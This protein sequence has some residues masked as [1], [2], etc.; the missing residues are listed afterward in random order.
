[1]SVPAPA[2]GRLTSMMWWVAAGW[3]AAIALA[4][5]AE[6]FSA[7]GVPPFALGL[8]VAAPPL[9]VV[10][11][12]AWSAPF[13]AW[14][15]ALD[16]RVLTAL[17]MWRVLGFGFIAAWAVGGLPAGFALPAGLGDVL[18]G[19]TAPLVAAR[20]TAPTASARR[21]FYGWTAFGVLDLLLAVT[22]GVLHSPSILGIL[23]TTPDTAAMARLPMVLI[24][25]FLVPAM[26]ALHAI[27]LVN[28]RRN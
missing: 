20:W 19:L 12:L 22:L 8:A 17:Q 18:V 23:A 28:A 9:L 3:G 7:P 27:S 13:R 6:V 5:A 24:P 21:I 10:G 25:A 26:L 16:L 15:R 4:G 14:A 1:M 2:T 11:L